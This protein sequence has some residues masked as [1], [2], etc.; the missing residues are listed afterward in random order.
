[1]FKVSQ[2]LT[3]GLCFQTPALVTQYHVRKPLL[4]NPGYAL[5]LELKF[6]VF[7]QAKETCTP[8]SVTGRT[9]AEIFFDRSLYTRLLLVHPCLSVHLNPKAEAQV[10]EILY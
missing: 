10:G 1:M 8:N 3:C 4:K 7:K 2:R 9:P 5:V 6:N